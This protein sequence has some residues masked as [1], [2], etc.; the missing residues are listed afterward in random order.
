MHMQ[1]SD[2]GRAEAFYGDLLGLEV[3][4]RSYPGAL[5]VAAGGY[6]HHLGLNTWAGRNAAPPPPDAAGLIAFALAIPGAAA[7]QAVIERVRQAELPL[8]DGAWA[9]RR[10]T[11]S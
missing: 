4:Q 11:G 1:V 3:M 10:R 7:W 6:H 9:V 2:L 5:F 8:E